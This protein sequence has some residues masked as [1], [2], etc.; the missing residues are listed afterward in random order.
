MVIR[1]AVIIFDHIR[2][3]TIVD[4]KI[5]HEPIVRLFEF[6]AAVHVVGL[7]DFSQHRFFSLRVDH[8]YGVRPAT[9]S[10]LELRMSF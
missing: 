7:A 3:L 4:N 6:I 2:D 5:R 8:V 1:W 10:F 9:G